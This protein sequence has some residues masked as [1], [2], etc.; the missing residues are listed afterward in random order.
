[1]RYD[2]YLL[3]PMS[4]YPDFNHPA[5]NEWAKR[6]EA[7]GFTVCNPAALD[8]R[9]PKPEKYTDYYARDMQFLPLCK[10]G[11]AL[12]GWER[13]KGALWECYTL[14]V[15]L[16][17]PVVRLPDMTPIIHLPKLIHTSA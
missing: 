9:F 1:M 3:G 7:D 11:A 6:L 2:F 17:R 5:F 13:S 15:L 10:A 14:A 12:P 8:A 16:Q 4:G